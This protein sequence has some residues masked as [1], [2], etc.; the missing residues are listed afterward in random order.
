M[1]DMP[2]KIKPRSVHVVFVVTK[3]APE[4]P[5]DAFV[6][7]GHKLYKASVPLYNQKKGTNKECLSMQGES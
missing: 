5:K 1:S 4:L 2:R 6:F 7:N 3:C